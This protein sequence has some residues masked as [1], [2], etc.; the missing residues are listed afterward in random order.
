M[1]LNGSVEIRFSQLKDII[2]LFS[3]QIYKI[4]KLDI[5]FFG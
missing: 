3:T 2:I 4:K 1:F 5:M